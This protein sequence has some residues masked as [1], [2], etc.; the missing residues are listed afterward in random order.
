M[1]KDILNTVILAISFLSLFAVGELLYR[2]LHI[3]V[4]Y[5]RKLIHVGTGI[6][7]LLFPAM[8]NNHWLVLFLCASF[9]IILWASFVYNFLP[10]INAINRPSHGSLCYP[11]AVYTSYLAYD[12]LGNPYFYF[13]MPM[14]ILSIC[15]PI[16]ALT[17]KKWPFG[18]FNIGNETKTIMGSVCFCIAAI[19]ISFTLF[20]VTSNT[21]TTIQKLIM[22]VVI[23]VVS[24]I[25]EGLSKKGVDNVTIP[26][27]VILTLYGITNA[28]H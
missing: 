5:T 15:D 27:V 18:K 19:V 21:L 11:L 14:L 24:A 10:S 20:T 28:V 9:A 25:T 12:Y 4:E 8:L 22:A 2:F 17:G 13:Y 16:A 6:I 26:L 7:T 3:K 1:Q 23:G